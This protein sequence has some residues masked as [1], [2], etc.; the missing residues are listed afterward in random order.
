MLA[1][2]D[3]QDA[4]SNRPPTGDVGGRVA[5]HPDP[6]Q[7]DRAGNLTLHLFQGDPRHVVPVTVQI[8]I[9]TDHKMLVEVEVAELDPGPRGGVPSQQPQQHIFAGP[10]FLQ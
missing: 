4:G 3:R 2:G 9:T 10:Q 1:G 7:I 6:P 8:A 5:N